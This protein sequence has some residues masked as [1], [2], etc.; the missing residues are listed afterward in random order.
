MVRV[1]L[2][3]ALGLAYVATS[4]ALS[5]SSIWART[6][7]QSSLVYVTVPFVLGLVSA[8]PRAFTAATGAATDLLLVVAFYWV[9]QLGSQYGISLWGPFFWSAA[10]LIVGAGFA[11]IGTLVVAARASLR[12]LLAGTFCGATA[13]AQVAVVVSGGGYRPV[14]GAAL[15]VDWLLWSGVVLFASRDPRGEAQCVSDFSAMS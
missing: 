8:R 1:L 14:E 10:G 15:M 9:N 11:C 7:A 3:A 5:D 6:M 2:V 12:R 4:A 13:C